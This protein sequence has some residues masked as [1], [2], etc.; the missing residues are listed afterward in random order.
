MTNQVSVKRVDSNLFVDDIYTIDELSMLVLQSAEKLG[1]SLRSID[2]ILVTAF[3][4]GLILS[5]LS[6]RFYVSVSKPQIQIGLSVFK[7]LRL[8][9]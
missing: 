4:K 9:I 3:L 6:R 7:K 5:I 2:V 8:N 1:K